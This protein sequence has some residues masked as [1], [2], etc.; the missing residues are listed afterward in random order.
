MT[1]KAAAPR[2]A[3]VRAGLP[4]VPVQS[5]G[6]ALLAPPLPPADFARKL[7]QHGLFKD[8]I[9]FVACCLDKRESV[10]WGC[11]CCGHAFGGKLAGKEAEALG[12]AVRWVIDPRDEHR[13]AAAAAGN[14]AGGTGTPIGALALATGWSS[15]SMAPSGLPEVKPPEFLTQTVVGSAIL[16]AAATAHPPTPPGPASTF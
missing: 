15:G 8:A 7:M 9:P 5:R 1:T 14:A 11:L 13:Q 16:A 3:I 4:A 12:A 10:W 2:G 6:A